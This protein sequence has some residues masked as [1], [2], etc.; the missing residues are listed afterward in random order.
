MLASAE[1][2][3]CYRGRGKRFHTLALHNERAPQPHRLRAVRWRVGQIKEIKRGLA[4][5][6][7]RG[8]LWLNVLDRMF[9]DDTGWCRCRGLCYES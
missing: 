3:P 1:D 9:D 5:I 7:A 6:A 4:R 2:A 8:I